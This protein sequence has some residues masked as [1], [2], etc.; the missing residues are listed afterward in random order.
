MCVRMYV[1]ITCKQTIRTYFVQNFITI[2][3]YVILIVFYDYTATVS[4]QSL[5][6][7]TTMNDM[8]LLTVML[9]NMDSSYCTYVTVL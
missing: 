5:L 4:C 3:A 1:C 2:I 6:R 7:K 8:D 9:I